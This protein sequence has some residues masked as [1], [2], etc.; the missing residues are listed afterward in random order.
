MRIYNVIC[1]RVTIDEYIKFIDANV[2]FKLSAREAIVKHNLLCE[3]TIKV[4]PTSPEYIGCVYR[5]KKIR[6]YNRIKVNVSIQEFKSFID[7]RIDY[8]FSARQAIMK[9]KL[10]CACYGLVP[11]VAN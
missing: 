2:D 6:R 3:N 4:S 5:G 11:I 1:I 9:K 7:A 10:L 8:S